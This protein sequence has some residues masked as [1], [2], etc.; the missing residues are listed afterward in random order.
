MKK[1]KL[2]GFD[3][4]MIIAAAVV[5]LLGAAAW[6]YLSGELQDAQTDDASAK[7]DFDKYSTKGDIV[8]SSTDGKILADN[9]DVLKTQLDPLI[10][11]KLRPKENKL[12]SIDKEDPVAWK[13][14]LD[15]EVQRLTNAAKNHLVALPPNFYFGFS[16][17]LNQN[18]GD[19]QTAVLSKQLVG[20]EEM[21]NILINAPV[22]GIQRIRR[23]YEEDP[24]SSAGDNNTTANDSSDQLASYSI[25]APGNV[26]TAYP[27]EIDFETS[28]ENLRAVI[29]GLIQSPYLFVVRSVT[30]ESTKPS[31][32]QIADLEKIA[33]TPPDPS[34]V[35][36]SP[37]E[38][39]D[40]S[41]TKG[42]QFLFGDATLKVVL[43]V[44]MIEWKADVSNIGKSPK[45][46]SP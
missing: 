12:G 27:F 6:W 23:S 45:P 16:R 19:E 37:G 31:S 25:D 38:V 15:G 5:A 11:A 3:L 1:L 41:S 20:V 7:A 35:N 18:P 4:G 21:A 42:P 33:G 24:H 9:I 22:K 36:S 34:V 13:H 43:R 30:V 28:P 14:D 8:V 46:L 39:A 29:D 26:Y 44:D 2:S 10:Q 32:P 17:Y 40:T